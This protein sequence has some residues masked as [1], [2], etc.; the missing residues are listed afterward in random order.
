MLGDRQENIRTT[1]PPK[2]NMCVEAAA[3]ALRKTIF[4]FQHG[5]LGQTSN[6]HICGK[7]GRNEQLGLHVEGKAHRQT[8]GNIYRTFS[9][10]NARLMYNA[11]PNI[12]VTPFH[13]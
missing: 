6:V 7:E 13:V 2:I 4:T 11:H 1:N 10:D 12:F 3:A 8:G 5:Q 9:I